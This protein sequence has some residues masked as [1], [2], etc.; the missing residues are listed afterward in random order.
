MSIHLYP[1]NEDECVQRFILNL[2]GTV[3]K[4]RGICYTDKKLED[5][6]KNQ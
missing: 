4:D 2:A 5:V 3:E 6:R 1:H